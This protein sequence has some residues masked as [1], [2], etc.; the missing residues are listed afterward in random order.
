MKP[1]ST[2]SPTRQRSKS[3]SQ[4]KEQRVQKRERTGR[5][6]DKLQQYP[7]VRGLELHFKNPYQLLV[8]TILSAQCTD[9]RVNQVTPALF[10][11]FPSP[12]SLAQASQHDVE[13]LIYSTGFYKAKAKN[14]IHCADQLV[15]NFKGRIPQAMDSLV[16]LPGV[17]RKTANVIRGNAFHQPAIVVDTHVKR[18][19]H[20]LKLVHRPDPDSIEEELQE[21]IPQSRWTTGSQQLL[22]HGRYVCIARHPKCHDC[23]IYSECRWEDKQ[24]T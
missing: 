10:K 22:L 18:V 6:L 19:T 16:S 17:G 5:I 4:T 3:P 12:Q 1:T 20:R 15:R 2:L 13:Q 24:S 7:P 21:L 8:A 14:L 23:H 11:R 9:A